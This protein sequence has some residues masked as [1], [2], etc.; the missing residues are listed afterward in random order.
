MS[1]LHDVANGAR[2]MIVD[3][4]PIVRRSLGRYLRTLGFDTLEAEDGRDCLDRFQRFAPSLCIIDLKMPRMGGI[5]ALRE[6]R[7]SGFEGPVIV[8]TALQ[9]IES[10]V[11]ATRLGAMEYLTKPFEPQVVVDA[12]GRCLHEYRRRTAE[13][14][15]VQPTGGYDRIVG[16]SPRMRKVFEVLTTLEG[17]AP[18]TV[19]IAGESGTGKDL[20]ARA[21]H[22]RG[23]R[24]NA[25]FVEVDCTSIPE[26]LMES[27]LF[28]HEKGSFTGAARQHRGLF[29]IASG[30]VVFLD[31]IGEMPLPAQAKLLRTLEN[32]RFKRVGGTQDLAFDACVVAA[33]NRELLSEVEQGRFREDLYYR[34]AI[35]PIH[36]PSLRDRAGDIPALVAHFMAHFA[37][38]FQRA[39]RRFSPDAMDSLSR[40][41][42]PGNV[43]ELRNVVERLVIFA[44]GPVVERDELPPE[45]RYA[46]NSVEPPPS[47][48][49]LLP[50]EGCNLDEVEHSLIVQALARTS[51]NQSAA[52]RLVGLSRFGL[53]NRMKKYGLLD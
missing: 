49:F 51:G 45:I 8:L 29:E 48:A 19:L 6:L 21:I 40:Y 42:W 22:A 30:G 25:P 13:L 43:R 36:V 38:L 28:G 20:V 23:P 24:S 32:R 10:A 31:E 12:V 17:I 9:D 44:R 15:A 18:P 14:D 5:E 26:S 4:E 50:E 34:L 1:L 37:Q 33:T 46:Q 53:R 52:A 47:P 11:E 2:L 39:T 35:I 7:K 16:E 3:D 27:T 41:R